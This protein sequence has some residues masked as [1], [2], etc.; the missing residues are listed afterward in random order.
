[1][2]TDIKEFE[3]RL[4]KHRSDIK[5]IPVKEDGHRRYFETSPSS[6]DAPN[7]HEAKVDPHRWL[8]CI[9]EFSDAIQNIKSNDWERHI[10]G[11]PSQQSVLK[12]PVK[13]VLVSLFL[14]VSLYCCSRELWDMETFS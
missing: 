8:S 13:I 5:V 9:D 7:T 14:S 10:P 4:A 3:Q 11:I 1:M 6:N 2:E 12:A